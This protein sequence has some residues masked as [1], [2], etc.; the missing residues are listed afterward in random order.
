MY[1]PLRSLQSS[2]VAR[3]HTYKMELE[4]MI[5]EGTS[6]EKRHPCPSLRTET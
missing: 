5:I 2:C 6:H 4:S 3:Y 1:L